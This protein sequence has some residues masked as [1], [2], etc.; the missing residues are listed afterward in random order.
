MGAEQDFFLDVVVA[1]GAAFVGALAARM[2][3]LPPLLGY[4]AVGIIIGPHVAGLVTNLDD[5]RT[6]ADFGVVLLLFAVGIEISSRDIRTLKHPIVAVGILQ[7]LATGAVAY[8]VGIGLGWNLEQSLV[9]GVV[10]SISST[11]VVLK[12]L[13][14]RGELT[15]LHGRLLTG[16]MLVQDLVFVGL[17]AIL[18]AFG[19]EDGFSVGELGLGALKAAGALLVMALVGAK[20]IP[21]LLRRVAGFGSREVFLLTVVAITFAA[22]ALTQEVGLSA[23][24]GAFL[25]G[26][27]L[28]ESDFG[29]RAL[30]EIVPLR[31]IFAA[32]FFVSLGMLADP[33]IL[34]SDLGTLA[35]VVGTIVVLKFV[36]TAGLIRGF[37]YLPHTA[38]LVG[39]GMVQIGEFGFV[40]TDSATDLG[41]A[42]EAF[43][44]LVVMAAVI[45]MGLTPPLMATG[46]ETI[47][48]LGKRFRLLRPYRQADIA[49][50]GRLPPLSG[51]VVVAGL[52][53][54]GSLVAQ[55]VKDRDIPLVAVELDPYLVSHWRSLGHH[56]INGSIANEHVLT[57]AR[58]RHARLLVLATGDPSAAQVA[59]E[60]CRRINP[61]LDIVARV[62]WREE[63]ESLK[64]LGVTEVVWPEM[65]AGLEMLRH[66]LLRYEASPTE[67]E[68]LIEGL[69]NELSFGAREDGDFVD[70]GGVEPPQPDVPAP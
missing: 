25:A 23:A 22:A 57:A 13:T 20:L 6:L 62:H 53:R 28:S 14:D 55:S 9:L 43:L 34:G 29:H 39:L 60:Y 40:L 2:L 7:M 5:V 69:R 41:I 31:D 52:G 59:V 66:T 8:L 21:L 32:L 70:T 33:A 11:M 36:A 18:P 1:I 12:T 26:L 51:H 45:T 35:A 50:G 15:S 24:V 67:V 4:L 38:L 3:R 48:C 56:A 58:I 19:G 65:E 17:I 27:A 49:S 68:P 63:G 61:D 16:L 10:V 44:S 30:S 47:A 42:D 54:I 37:G 64:R 46:Y